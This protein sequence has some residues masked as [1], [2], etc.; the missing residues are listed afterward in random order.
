ML[1]F[2]EIFIVFFI[3]LGPVKLLMLFVRLT[4]NAG[5]DLRRSLAWKSFTFSTIV[6]FSVALFGVGLVERWKI[7]APALMIA[8]GVILFI[9]SVDTLGQIGKSTPPPPPDHP[10]AALAVIP[11]AVPGIITPY[12]VAA[13]LL[14]AMSPRAQSIPGLVTIL[15]LLLTVMVL[16]LFSM[17]GSR[18]LLKVV[19]GPVT[20]QLAGAVLGVLQ[21]A[22]AVQIILN[23]LVRLGVPGK[24]S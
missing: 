24:I 13:V 22:L 20:M 8:A 4:T 16:N 2:H 15:V 19:G 9:W 14:F 6:L 10:S 3:T 21:A 7:S 17:L 18:R 23:A 5:D 12:G 11:L 1:S